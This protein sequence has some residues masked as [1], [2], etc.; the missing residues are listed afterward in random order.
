M[1]YGDL[2]PVRAGLV[3]RA[4]RW[5]WSS[6]RHYAY[7]EHNALITDAPEY[8]ALGETAPRRRRAYLQL[9]AVLVVDGCS[10]IVMVLAPFIGSDTWISTQRTAHGLS[11]PS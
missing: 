7:G 5:P 1:R 3:G 4:K 2:N 11:P 8:L 10:P 6:H 9:F